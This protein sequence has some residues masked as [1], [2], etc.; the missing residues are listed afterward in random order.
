MHSLAVAHARQVEELEPLAPGRFAADAPI[1]PNA[2]ARLAAAEYQAWPRLAA[3]QASQSPIFIV[4]FPRSGTTLLEQVLDAHPKL[5]SMDE[6][7]FFTILGNELSD[8]GV[9]MPQDIVRLNQRDCDELRKRYLGLVSEKIRRR[10]DTRLVDKNPLNML[11]LPLIKRLFPESKFIL[12]LRHPC[13]VVLSNYMQNYRSSVLASACSTLERTARAYVAAME[14]WLHHE[15]IIRPDV[16]VSRYEDLVGDLPRQ[17][18]LIAS[19]LGLED[20]AP[21]LEYDRHAREKGFIA[22]PS[23]TEVIQP[24]SRRRMDRWR[25]YQREFEPILPILEPMLRHWDYAVAPT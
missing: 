2:V 8:L 17:T 15:G 16:L 14:A 13:D 4:G 18:A 19:F 7:P 24:V 5:Q 6:R 23:Y 10:W 12:A 21:M 25:R 1:L 3:P 9:R 11:W 20:A 22:T